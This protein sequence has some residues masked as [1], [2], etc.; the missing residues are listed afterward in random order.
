MFIN[1]LYVSLSTNSDNLVCSLQRSK[2]FLT[3]THTHTDDTYTIEGV[4]RDTGVTDTQLDTEIQEKD[5]YI[6]AGYFETVNKAIFL[7]LNLVPAD[8]GDVKR[9]A[10]QEGTQAAMAHA[11]GIWRR[12]NPARATFRTLITIVLEHLKDGDLARE[13]AAYAASN[14]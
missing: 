4:K 1:R 6:L 13:I 2:S 5:I 8:R 12:V 9:I 11:L 3:H 7:P 10:N 14:G